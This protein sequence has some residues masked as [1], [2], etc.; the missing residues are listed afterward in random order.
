MRDLQ[1]NAGLG[2]Y[3]GHLAR[4]NVQRL[5]DA[6]RLLAPVGIG[7]P[8]TT[9]VDAHDPALINANGHKQDLHMHH[10]ARNASQVRSCLPLRIKTGCGMSLKG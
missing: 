8:D 4:H 9:S 1:S 3:L 10:D 2:D 6:Y 7:G 5:L